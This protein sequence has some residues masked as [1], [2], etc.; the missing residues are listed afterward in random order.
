ML[1]F[2]YRINLVRIVISK[3]INLLKRILSLLSYL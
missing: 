2:K 1:L 3:P